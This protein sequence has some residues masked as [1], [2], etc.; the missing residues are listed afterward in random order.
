VSDPA[1]IER[2][3]P[4]RRPRSGPVHASGW[5]RS[6]TRS[7]RGGSSPSTTAAN[8]LAGGQRRRG[9][10]VGHH[11]QARR[12]GGHLPEDPGRPPPGCSGRKTAGAGRSARLGRPRLHRVGT[13]RATSSTAGR[14]GGPGSKAGTLGDA[15]TSGGPAADFLLGGRTGAGAG[16]GPTTPP[17]ARPSRSSEPGGRDPDDAG[18]L[19]RDLWSPSRAQGGSHNM[20]QIVRNVPGATWTMVWGYRPACGWAPPRSG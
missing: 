11:R 9:R 15:L 16:A 13:R 12:E 3:P 17:R 18:H 7:I 8:G 14:A 4:G 2:V 1:L 20:T 6:S 19:R 10:R 5:P